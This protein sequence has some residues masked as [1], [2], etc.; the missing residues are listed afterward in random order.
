M[1][2]L[3]ACIS[4]AVIFTCAGMFI[5][6]S[7]HDSVVHTDQGQ[8]AEGRCESAF[9]AAVHSGA[10]APPLPV[11]GAPPGSASPLP[12]T[13]GCTGVPPAHKKLSTDHQRNDAAA[14]MR[15]SELLSQM[16]APMLALVHLALRKIMVKPGCVGSRQISPAQP[17]CTYSRDKHV[18]AEHRC[19]NQHLAAARCSM[20]ETCRTP[21]ARAPAQ[22]AGGR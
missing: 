9:G 12:A 11:A 6:L 16:Q 4:V 14:V 21:C 7:N 18:H 22:P 19:R 15:V 13:R 10:A 2:L 3:A 1:L 8:S 20:R 5:T 17:V